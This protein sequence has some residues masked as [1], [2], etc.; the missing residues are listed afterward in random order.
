[1]I[2]TLSNLAIDRLA[3][4]HNQE[5]NKIIEKALDRLKSDSLKDFTMNDYM[6]KITTGAL[7][8]S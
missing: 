2:S 4:K 3:K 1:V 6:N 8:R 7:P 5:E